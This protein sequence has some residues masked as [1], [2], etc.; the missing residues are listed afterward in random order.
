MEREGGM[1]STLEQKDVWD[2][3]LSSEVRANYF[4]DLSSG[5]QRAQKLITWGILLMS[6]GAFATLLADWL[7]ERYKWVRPA[8]A[9]MAA[10][11][12]FWSLVARNERNAVECSDLFFQWSVL[13]R[14]FKEL[15]GNV[16]DESAHATLKSLLTKRDELSRRCTNLP[17]KQSLVLKWEDYVVQQHQREWVA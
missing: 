4:A 16:H 1:L 17:N 14:E 9:F 6:S 10:A 7:P 3:W 13:G 8:L 2:G 11:L 5:Y 12:S 15:W